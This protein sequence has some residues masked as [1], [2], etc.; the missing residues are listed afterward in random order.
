MYTTVHDNSNLKLNV[1]SHVKLMQPVSH[2]MVQTAEAL[3][4]S[5][6]V[7]VM[8]VCQYNGSLKSKRS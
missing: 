1:V 8:P 6:S 3:N 4:T 7:H 5:K 2:G